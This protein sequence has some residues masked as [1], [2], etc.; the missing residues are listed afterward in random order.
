MALV[1][2]H[3]YVVRRLRPNCERPSVLHFGLCSRCIEEARFCV[4]PGMERI[5]RITKKDVNF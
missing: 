2:A 5:G 4:E 3:S 1:K